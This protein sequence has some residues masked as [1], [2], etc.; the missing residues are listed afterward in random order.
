VVKT[1]Y[2]SLGSNIGDR[3][4]LLQ[5]AVDRLESPGLTVKRISSIYE[6]EPMYV[7]EQR[8]FLNLAVEAE[9][10]LFPMMLLSRI[11]KIELA[12]GRKRTGAPNGPRTIDIDI[13]FYG[14]AAVHSVKLE[15]PHPRLHER[16]FVLAPMAEL[17]PDFRHPRLH[18]TM[19]ELLSQVEGQKVRK[20]DISLRIVRDPA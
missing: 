11:Q 6:T 8:S 5:D 16:R 20:L 4:Q 2:F 18:R 19:R 14:T 3:Q 13:L 12:L 17:A 10:S 7:K 9:T 15:I 1:V